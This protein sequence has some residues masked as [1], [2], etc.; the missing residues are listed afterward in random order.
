MPRAQLLLLCCGLHPNRRRSATI[1]LLRRAPR[2]APR[3]PRDSRHV[4]RHRAR[5]ESTKTRAHRGVCVSRCRSTFPA[6][7]SLARVQE[8]YCGLAAAWVLSVPPRRR[9]GRAETRRGTDDRPTK[10]NRPRRSFSWTDGAPRGAPNHRIS[11]IPGSGAS[12]RAFGGATA[13]GTP[14]VVVVVV[15][16]VH[17]R[18]TPRARVSRSSSRRRASSAR[19]RA[20]ARRWPR[21]TCHHQML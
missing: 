13:A 6:S 14:R 3:S 16:V 19:A 12:G 1:P 7:S 11:H 4:A 5:E 20:R 15:A 10:K 18:G 9:G 2:S 21:A 8:L 17:H